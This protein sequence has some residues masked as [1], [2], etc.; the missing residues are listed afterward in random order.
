VIYER[1]AQRK[2]ANLERLSDVNARSKRKG[3]GIMADSP[4]R[5]QIIVRAYKKTTS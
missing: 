2:R 5:Y 1:P 4:L 3:L